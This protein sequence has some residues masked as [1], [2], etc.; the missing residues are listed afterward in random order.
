MGGLNPF[1]ALLAALGSTAPPALLAAGYPEFEVGEHNFPP[2]SE[3]VEIPSGGGILRGVFVPSDPGAPVVLH[4]LESMGS[5]T[6]GT[7]HPLGYPLLWELRDRGF[8]SLMLDY[9][10]VGASSG[11]RSPRN[12]AADAAAM[13]RE[14]HRRSGRRSH[15]IVLRGAS[16]GTL[17]V[18]SLLRAGARPRAV[19]LV[20]PVRAETVARNWFRHYHPFLSRAAPLFLRLPMRVD[21]VAALRRWRGPLLVS[22]PENDYVLPPREQPL[23]RETVRRR[24]ARWVSTPYTHAGHVL[25]HHY[26]GPDETSFLDAC[27][28]G[29]PNLEARDPRYPAVA[30]RWKLLETRLY[31]SLDRHGHR[32]PRVVAWLRRIPHAWLAGLDQDELDRLLD[33]RG[34]EGPLPIAD[35]LRLAAYIADEGIPRRPDALAAFAAEAGFRTARQRALVAKAAG[36]PDAILNDC[37]RDP[38]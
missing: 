19:V 38:A 32:D 13:W 34:P 36:L 6:Y 20:A 17:A 33:L 11:W 25:A 23:V 22:A 9:R 21:L 8:A 15:R 28:P 3:K 1:R 27:F 18:A 4:L 37:D 24:G 10:G 29:L 16:F 31:A 2:G 7:H 35:L 14:A 30:R 12:V 26:L 5:V